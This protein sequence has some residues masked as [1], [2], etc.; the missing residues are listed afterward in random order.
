MTHVY[1]VAGVV[2]GLIG[3][4]LAWGIKS[5]WSEYALMASG[6]AAAALYAVLVWKLA[7]AGDQNAKDYGRVCEQVTYLQS[8]IQRLKADHA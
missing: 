7:K 4:G 8:E 6:W 5:P 3:L 2:A 1:G